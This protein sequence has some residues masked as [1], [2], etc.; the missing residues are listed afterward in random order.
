MG[1]TL[2]RADAYH[3]ARMMTVELRTDRIGW[4]RSLVPVALTLLPLTAVAAGE[5]VSNDPADF[6]VESIKLEGLQ[7]ISEGT[8]YNYLPVNIGDRLNRQRVREAIRALYASGFFRDVQL[9]RDSGTLEV[10]LL[11]RPS[12]ESFEITGNKDIKTEDLQKSLRGVGLAAGK[13]FD[14]SVLEDVT[15]YL[16]DQYFSRGKYSVRIQA[17]VEEESGNRVRIKIE[18]KEG[19]RAKVREINIVGM[20]KFRQQDILET[21]TLKTP[22]WLSWYKQD[23][24][25]SRESL[26]G[27][28]EKVRDYYMERGYANFNV[29]STQVSV[30]P[31]K[32]DIFVTI[33]VDEGDVFKLGAIK[34]AGTFVVPRQELERLLLVSPGQVF[35]RKLIASTQQSIQNRLGRDGYAFAKVEPVPTPDNATH[36]VQLTFF[37][38]PGNRVYVRNITFSGT[39][40]INDVVL[41]REVR[42]LEGG[43][44][45]NTS[46]ER[47][48]QRLQRLPYIKQVDFETVPV[49]SAP[50]Q[51]D[52]NF[53]MEDASASSLSGGIG[54]SQILGFSINGSFVDANVLGTGDRDAIE[55][56]VGKYSKIVNLSQTDPYVTIDGIARTLNVSYSDIS[57]FTA[58]ASEFATR[59]YQSGFSFAYPI[60]EY[61]VARLGLSY[62]HTDLATI[63]AYSS[64]QLQDWL[65]DNGSP[66]FNSAGSQYVQGTVYDAVEA[67]TGWSYDSRNRTL[68]PTQG[69]LHTVSLTVTLP[70]L[71]VEYAIANY[72]YQQYLH[73]PLPFIG[74]V[75]ISVNTRLGYGTPLGN[76]TAL[77]PNR[78]FFLGGSDSVR[79]FREGTLGPRD[80]L[81]YPYGGD[82]AISTQV[83]AILPM[84]DKFAT[85]ARASLFFDAGNA[86]YYGKVQFKDQAGFYTT[87]HFNPQQLRTSTGVAVE[88]L[89]PMG[90]FRFSLGFPIN[91]QHNT[92]K[93]YGDETEMFQF[94]I[95]NAF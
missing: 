15:G 77:P 95:G 5:P 42:Q 86:F 23:D 57:R 73:L 39:S 59:T 50:D 81:G 58:N 22:N 83:D 49:T 12:I 9:R 84:P 85:S 56:T 32:E 45:S 55:A 33:N 44:L 34:L 89:S 20:T 41:R 3:P 16:T 91:Y 38:D 88:W 66:Y 62:A 82:T 76:T 36:T 48:K 70:G 51:V 80:S 28:I 21:L 13:T 7:R 6:T 69:A 17:K 79:G 92:W 60:S 30:A 87:Y 54:Y 64:D 18:I 47:S 14:R 46:L 27:D 65:R 78:D 40:H 4:V 11:E 94:S 8:V 68:F 53:K 61:Q 19:K 29:E 10:I 25:Y 31:E 35:N 93:Y 90:L 75:P 72:Q 71:G 37:I 1:N 74:A 24:R 67:S 63:T 43:W 2:R 26:Q 52:V